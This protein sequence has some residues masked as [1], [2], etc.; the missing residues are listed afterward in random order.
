MFSLLIC[1]YW[2][3][4]FQLKNNKDK[5]LNSRALKVAV[6]CNCDSLAFP[7]IKKL[8][9]EGNLMGIGILK[10][11]QKYLEPAL[12]AFGIEKNTITYF[13]K[14][15][16]INEKAKW[17]KSLQIDAVWVFC[18]PWK[19]PKLLLDIPKNGFFNF[20]FGLFPKYKG[21]D[22]IFWQIKNREEKG[23]L[24]IHHVNDEMDG[25]DICWREEINIMPGETHG[26]HAQK[27]GFIAAEI[28][29]KFL[30]NNTVK[31]KNISLQKDLGFLK[32]PS[33]KDLAID[34][35][36][37]TADEIEFLVN[38]CN[39]EYG[40][41]AAILRGSEVKLLE[42]APSGLNDA[43]EMAPGTIAYADIVYGIIVACKNNQFLRIMIVSTRD[44]FLS[45]SKLFSLGL[46]PGE[47]FYNKFNN[48]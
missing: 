41:A 44:G 34:W 3:H 21:A 6:I 47:R 9:D 14:N 30:E 5:R 42:V 17:L 20:H 12:L 4:Y 27:M 36:N 24:I 26:L 46:K 32:K 48:S 2:Q 22:P 16:W 31:E 23:G 40:G 25:G 35:E 10:R 39:K 29:D 33:E 13:E 15:N 11:Y 28:I 43:P 38:A 8:H 1:I 45:G 18:F 37:Q 19:F 7:T